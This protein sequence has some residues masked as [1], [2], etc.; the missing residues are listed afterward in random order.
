MGSVLDTWAQEQ[1][2]C[3]LCLNKVGISNLPCLFVILYSQSPIWLQLQLSGVTEYNSSLA[4]KWA[5]ALY[6]KS[7]LCKKVGAFYDLLELLKG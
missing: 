4:I 5:T 2:G 7:Q 6:S 3:Q 1:K